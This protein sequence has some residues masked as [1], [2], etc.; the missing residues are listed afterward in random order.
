MAV[1]YPKSKTRTKKSNSKVYITNSER[2]N[3]DEKSLITID[4]TVIRKAALG[5]CHKTLK[6]IDKAKQE[7]EQFEKVDKPAYENWIQQNFGELIQKIRSYA[8]EIQEKRSLIDEVQE[9]AFIQKITFIEAYKIIKYKREHPEEFQKS[10]TPNEEE[11]FEEDTSYDEDDVFRDDLNDFFNKFNGKF[12]MNEEEFENFKKNFQ[13][14]KGDKNKD[15][16]FRLKER[17]RLIVQKL[18]PDKNKKSSQ[19]EKE[20]WYEAQEAYKQKDLEKLDFIIALY[21]IRFG[22]IGI[23]SSIFDLRFANSKLEKSLKQ[24]SQIIRR[25][26]HEP[27]WLFLKLKPEKLN[28]LK[29]EA[30]KEFKEYERNTNTELREINNLI[31][32]WERGSLAFGNKNSSKVSKKQNDD[33]FFDF[34]MNL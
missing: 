19:M 23:D 15:L 11:T 32:K 33:N 10:D 12:N 4:Q 30:A 9:E 2:I 7:I 31:D 29:R 25:A 6:K 16:D 24:F 14:K 18:H 21:N 3:F 8:I 17:Y 20:L 1:K 34:Y 13:N 22:S 5:E 27:S 26:K 28:S